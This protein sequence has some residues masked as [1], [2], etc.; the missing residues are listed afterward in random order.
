MARDDWTLPQPAAAQE[1]PKQ[2]WAKLYPH[3][4]GTDAQPVMTAPS[5]AAPVAEAPKEDFG[6]MPWS[7]VAGRAVEAAP[8]SALNV[9]K[10]LVSAVS[11]PLDTLGK[12]GE[13]E[14]GAAHK[15]GLVDD[16]TAGGAADALIGDYAEKYGSKAGFKERLATDPF[17]IGLDVASVVPGLGVGKLG[18]VGKGLE[19]VARA[20]DPLNAVTLAGKVARTALKPVEGVAKYSQGV[21]SGVPKS[22]LKIAEDTGRAGTKEQREAFKEFASGKGDHRE[23]AAKA[24]DAVDELKQEASDQYKADHASLST[25][26][27][28]MGD[29]QAAV[30]SVKTKLDPHGL[31][32][33]PQ[34]MRDVNDIEAKVDAA[35]SHASPLARN[36][37]SLDRLKQHVND[38]TA[39][40]Q[41]TR[42]VGAINEIAK[43][44]RDTISAHDPVYAQM[45]ERWSKWRQELMDFQRTLG[46][47][48][49]VAETSRLAR[50]LH[51]VRMPAGR[52]NDKM[53]LLDMLG[54]TKAGHTLP[55]M[56]AGASAENLLPSYLRGAGLATLGYMAYPNPAAGVA[57]ALTASPRVAGLSNYALGRAGAGFDALPQVPSLATD[58]MSNLGDERPMRA[59]GGSVK[60][61]HAAR[62]DALIRAAE[63]SR[64]KLGQTTRPLLGQPDDA[65]A[66]ALELANRNI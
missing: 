41:G 51:S 33:F 40:Y 47:S 24:M 3:V 18:A 34:V 60:I 14:F 13:L 55:Q 36:A 37:E 48:D 5:P 58:A 50:L 2:D 44:I 12:I 38:L 62:A 65:V 11:H 54:K 59:S 28:P 17:N 23:I 35:A 46:T 19:T 64:K 1:A 15:L 8:G 4:G 66:K 25:T 16:P 39:T 42:H 49:R 21:A 56:I 31:G 10:S 30:Q 61:N 52:K 63:R 57:A 29:I 22:V 27:L 7:E 53:D 20:G 6:A 26:E 45:M 43:A 32:L 9:G